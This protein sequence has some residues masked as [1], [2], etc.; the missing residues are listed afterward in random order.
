[1]AAMENL[2]AGK[3][4]SLNFNKYKVE[5]HFDSLQ[6]WSYMIVFVFMF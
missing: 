5:V 3:E 2:V 1:M 6:T 4:F